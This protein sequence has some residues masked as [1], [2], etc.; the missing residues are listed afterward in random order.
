MSLISMCGDRLPRDVKDF[1]ESSR[2]R[3][4]ESSFMRKADSM[5]SDEYKAMQNLKTAG[6]TQA[7]VD[8]IVR[9][10]RANM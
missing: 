6:A 5:G 7:G 2:G 4:A 10:I 8:S 3:D 9:L 1:L